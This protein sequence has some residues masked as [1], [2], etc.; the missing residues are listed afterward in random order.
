[1]HWPLVVLRCN[2][3]WLARFKREILISMTFPIFVRSSIIRPITSAEINTN[4]NEIFRFEKFLQQ[5]CELLGKACIGRS[6]FFG[7]REGALEEVDLF[8]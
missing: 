1:M 5:F 4:R 3:R 8:I 2:R 7:G 6:R